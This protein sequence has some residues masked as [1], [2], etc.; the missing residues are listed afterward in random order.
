MLSVGALSLYI[1]VRKPQHDWS[2]SE[3]EQAFGIPPIVNRVIRGIVSFN[4][5]AVGLVA[6]LRTFKIL[7]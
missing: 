5:I 3:V 2:K 4:F 1:L 6:L 7:P